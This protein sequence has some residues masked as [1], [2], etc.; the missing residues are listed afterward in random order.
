MSQPKP[1]VKSFDYSDEDNV[2]SKIL[3]VIVLYKTPLINSTTFQTLKASLESN[4]INSRIDLLVCDN[5]PEE[6]IDSKECV[7][8]ECFNLFHLYDSSNPG[9]SISYNR[10]AEIASAK[11]KKWLLMFDQDTRLPIDGLHQYIKNLKN[12]PNF[13]L[14]VPKL[15]VADKLMSPCRYFMYRGSHLPEIK[16]G[17]NRLKRKNILNNGV[18]VSLDAFKKVGGYDERVWLYF[19]DFV[20]FD[21]LKKHYKEFVVLDC[22]VEHEL[23]S[24]DYRDIR[25]AIE[26]FCHYCQGAKAAS[27]SNSSF[28]AY[29]GYTLTV[30]L[31]RSCLNFL[32][33]FDFPQEND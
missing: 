18:L 32:F 14:Y 21:R 27:V 2:I 11:E 26:R 6:H 8:S 25:F 33:S 20:F 5:S 4:F 13:P 16:A 29:L 22:N 15:F 10:A 30:G 12:L 9:I 19:S 1:V 23:S 3:F 7:S 28:N 17:I 31:R 24:S